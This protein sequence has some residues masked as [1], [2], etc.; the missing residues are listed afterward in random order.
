M[1]TNRTSNFKRIK[2]KNLQIIEPLIID[3]YY[4]SFKNVDEV[5]V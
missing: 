1:N 2:N 5:I 4:Q 3:A